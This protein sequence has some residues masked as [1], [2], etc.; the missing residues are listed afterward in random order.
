MT[1]LPGRGGGRHPTPRGAAWLSARRR[2]PVPARACLSSVPAEPSG[3]PPQQQA[4]RGLLSNGLPPA[5]QPSPRPLRARQDQVHR[6][7]GGGDCVAA[8]PHARG[9]CSV[10]SA[11]STA[12]GLDLQRGPRTR[13]MTNSVW[14]MV[15]PRGLTAFSLLP[16]H[17]PLRPRNNEVGRTTAP[18]ASRHASVGA[19]YVEDSHRGFQPV[20]Q[21]KPSPLQHRTAARCERAIAAD[22]DNYRSSGP[23]RRSARAAAAAAS[24]SCSRRRRSSEAIECPVERIDGPTA[25][26]ERALLAG[27]HSR[28]WLLRST[29]APLTSGH[30]AITTANLRAHYDT[31]TDVW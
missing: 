16:R 8:A 9:F 11:C 17:L 15:N 28:P 6:P 1:G 24:R 20:R 21:Q 12:S 26:Y 5:T 14:L 7:T 18:A 3:S 13:L 22:L 4:S 10:H 2:A 19:K 29:G 23:C 31:A 25:A 27:T 30:D